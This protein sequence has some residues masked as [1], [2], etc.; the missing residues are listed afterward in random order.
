MTI[1]YGQQKKKCCEQFICVSQ[2]ATYV[3]KQDVLE[4]SLNTTKNVYPEKPP[5]ISGSEI[6]VHLVNKN[7]RSQ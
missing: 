7:T 3:I 4:K 6:N 1:F 5:K 2:A